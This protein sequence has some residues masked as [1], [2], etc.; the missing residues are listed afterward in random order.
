MAKAP[1]EWD[2]SFYVG[3]CIYDDKKFMVGVG[4][5][6]CDTIGM[7]DGSFAIVPSRLFDLNYADYCRMVVSVYHATLFGK[8]GK[9]IGICFQKEE[10][11]NAL[12]KELKKRWDYAKK[13]I[14]K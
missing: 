8:N 14:K 2:E 6:V 10:D 4:K 1:K 7:T 12:C 13:K 11:A 9:Y 5:E 3:P